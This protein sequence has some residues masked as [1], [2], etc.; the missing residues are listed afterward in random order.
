MEDLLDIGQWRGFYCY[1][2]EYGD[3]LQGK[4]AEFRMFIEEYNDG[5]FSGRVIDW[6]GVGANGEVSKLNGSLNGYLINFT[7][8]YSASLII[9]EWG[10]TTTDPNIP[11]HTVIYEGRYDPQAKCFSGSWI[12]AMNAGTIDAPL[13]ENFS[14]GTW[15]MSQQ[16]Q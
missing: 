7:K 2:P 15:R 11:G 14:S 6:E 10:N 5:R 1:G 12:I 3:M 4:E 16:D 9:D 13:I 8:E